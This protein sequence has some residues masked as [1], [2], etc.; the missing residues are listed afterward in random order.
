MQDRAFVRGINVAWERAGAG[1]AFIWGHGLNN[2]RAAENEFGLVDQEALSVHMDVV[3]YDARGHGDT[4][5]TTGVGDYNW[6]QLAL[7]QFALADSLGVGSYIAA[8]ASLGAATALHAA[9]LEPERIEALVLVVPP[10]GWETRAAQA[11]RYE[12]MASIIDTMGVEPLVTGLDSVPVADPLLEVADHSERQVRNLRSADPV[13][14]AAL[15]RG[16]TTANLPDREAVAAVAVPALIL[17]W[18]GDA[19]H[20]ES[21]AHELGRLIEV[22][23]V[24]IAS[25]L[26][27]MRTWTDRIVEFVA[28]LG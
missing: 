13:R 22:S 6:D 23:S 4:D 1:P 9:V 21:S 14:L 18:S 3:R 7:D 19:G 25:T 5:L 15:L 10:T 2:S 20:P 26:D 17:A 11:R 24:H 8:G 12:T 16:A 28:G 27:E